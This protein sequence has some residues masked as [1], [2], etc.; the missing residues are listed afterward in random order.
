MSQ[1]LSQ[2]IITAAIVGFE[3]QKG[4]IASKIAELR[5]MLHHRN[6]APKGP[7]LKG[8]MSAASRRRIAPD[9]SKSPKRRISKE[10]MKRIIAATKRRWALKRA[11]EAKAKRAAA[12]RT[13]ART[14]MLKAA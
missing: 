11:E 13:G 12:K 6:T 9:G 2:E 5:I 7:Q 8:K 4:R 3:A 10:G 14:V 1:E